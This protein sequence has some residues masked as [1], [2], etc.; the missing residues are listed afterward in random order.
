MHYGN[1]HGIFSIERYMAFTSSIRGSGALTMSS[2]LPY[3]CFE[4]GKRGSVIT[5]FHLNDFCYN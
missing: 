5:S 4:Y 1:I 2:H 3:V